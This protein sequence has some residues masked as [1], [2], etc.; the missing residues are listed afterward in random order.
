MRKQNDC[1]QKLLSYGKKLLSYLLMQNGFDLK[2]CHDEGK[3]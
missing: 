1:G 2:Q 3:L